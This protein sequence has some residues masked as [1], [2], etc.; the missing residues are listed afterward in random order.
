VKRRAPIIGALVIAVAVPGFQ[1]YQA[2]KGASGD[3]G[4]AAVW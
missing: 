2:K 4:E 1:L 3:V